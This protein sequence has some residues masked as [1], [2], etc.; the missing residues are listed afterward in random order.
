MP[1]VIMRAAEAGRSGGRVRLNGRVTG[2]GRSPAAAAPGTPQALAAPQATVTV[3]VKTPAGWVRD[4]TTP[5][6]DDGTFAV[7]VAPVKDT[8]YRAVQPASR[9][10]SQP[11]VVR[12][13]LALGRPCTPRSIAAHRGFW[14][15]GSVS[16]GAYLPVRVTLV[17]SVGRSWKVV[18]TVLVRT[19]KT[20]VWRLSLRL[21]AGV[22]RAYVADA[23]RSHAPATSGTTT[24]RVR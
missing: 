19:S 6:Q 17:R 7:D 10:L 20:G 11:V 24:F 16:H 8:A 12:V 4:T 13:A 5:V 9:A 23:D 22:W 15:H 21:N 1:A 18:R 14:L 2:A 3:E